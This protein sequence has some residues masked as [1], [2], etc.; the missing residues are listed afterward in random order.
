[1]SNPF[2]DEA[3]EYYVLVNAEFQHSL[4]PAAITVPSGWHIVH[5][6]TSR[7]SSLE[8][9]E[10]NWLDIRPRKVSAVDVP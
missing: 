9:I 4:W 10:K 8:F 7:G 6:K 5:G 3:G 2:D 1:M